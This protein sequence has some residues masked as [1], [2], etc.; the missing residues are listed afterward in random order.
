MSEICWMSAIELLSAYRK[1]KLSPVEVVKTL[2]AR[3]DEV[4]PKIN[5][6]VT[7]TDE[8]ALS[9]ARESEAAFQKGK[10][11]PLEG[12]PMVIKD[13]MFT[14]GIRT[15]F[16]PK[17]EDF[18]WTARCLKYPGR[19]LLTSGGWAVR[20]KRSNLAGSIWKRIF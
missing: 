14:K 7:R 19:R 18:Q 13:N 20:W 10:T 11:R 16:G 5:A 12:V 9:A 1:R 3:M 6:L 2:L 4:N 8:M 17:L 15:T